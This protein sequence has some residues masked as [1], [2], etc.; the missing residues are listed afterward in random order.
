MQNYL[1][2]DELTVIAL[3][4]EGFDARGRRVRYTVIVFSGV[5]SRFFFRGLTLD[6]SLARDKKMRQFA[7]GD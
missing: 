3:K 5:A 4:R 6:V 7:Y 1:L 2:P